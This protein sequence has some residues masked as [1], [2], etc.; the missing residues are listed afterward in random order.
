LVKKLREGGAECGQEAKRLARI[1]YK[2]DY[3]EQFNAHSR[4][5]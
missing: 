1:A 3:E 5:F 2:Q 4:F